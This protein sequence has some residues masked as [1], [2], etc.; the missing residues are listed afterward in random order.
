[1]VLDHIAN[2]VN[3]IHEKCTSIQRDTQAILANTTTTQTAAEALLGKVNGVS[4]EL[5]KT[6]TSFDALPTLN[7]RPLTAMVSDITRIRGAFQAL[8]LSTSIQKLR[9][10]KNEQQNWLDKYKPRVL[11]LRQQVAAMQSLIQSL[12]DIPCDN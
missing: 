7:T 3:P 4:E 10:G 2:Q 5:D 11:K 6:T 8:K 1:M 12:K 9:Q